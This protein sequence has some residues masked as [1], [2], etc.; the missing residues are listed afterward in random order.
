MPGFDRT[1]PAG[2]GPRTGGGFGLCPPGPPVY[3]RQ[4]GYYGTGWGGYPRGS[5]RG[6]VWGGKRAYGWLT[7]Q[8][9][10]F[11]YPAPEDE[12]KYLNDYIKSL[13]QE[14]SNIEK[15][16]DELESQKE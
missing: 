2:M 7:P 10:F 13:K 16:L 1:G 8:H 3:L 9:P 4:G 12:K 6:R 14:I 11:D 15:R 5:R